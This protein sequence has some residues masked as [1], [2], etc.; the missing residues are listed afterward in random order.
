MADA[1]ITT[2]RTRLG[3]PHPITELRLLPGDGGCFEVMVNDELIY[4]K[5][6]TGQHTTNEYI[7]DEVRKRLS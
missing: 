2:F 3:Q 5:R 6:A 4:S 1:L 7:L